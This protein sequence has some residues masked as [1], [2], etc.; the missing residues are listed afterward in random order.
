MKFKVASLFILLALLTFSFPLNNA[1]PTATASSPPA[2]P[3]LG[4]T[5]SFGL[6]ASTIT[7]TLST[8]DGDVGSGTGGQTA[9][10]T[11][12]PPG[13]NHKNNAA[14]TSAN[15]DL[16][17]AIANAR[18][19]TCDTTNA[20]AVTL[21]DS[22]PHGVH[23]IGGAATIP[24]T[25]TLNDNGGV[26]LFKISGAL[27]TAAASNV[28]LGIGVTS[29]KVFWLIDGATSIGAGSTFAGTVLT[30]A[31]V[32]VGAGSDINGRV[33]TTAAATISTSTITTAP[34]TIAPIMIS[35]I[36]LSETQISVTFSENLDALTVNAVDFTVT[37][38]I[39]TV[40]TAIVS[41]E[42]V[43]LNLPSSSLSPGDTPTVFLTGIV[44]DTAGNDS[45]LLQTVVASA[46]T[47]GAIFL[48]NAEPFGL[49]AYDIQNTNP[50]VVT[51]D[52]G[53]GLAGQSPAIGTYT[54]IHFN[55]PVYADANNDLITAI[56]DV[57]NRVCDFDYAGATVL[58]NT[59]PPGV[60]CIDGVANITGTLQLEG[61][62][63]YIFKIT[64]ALNSAVGTQVVLSAGAD[65]SQVFWAP[66]GATTLG[67]NSHLVGTILSNVAVT[68]GVG[69]S[70]DG[71]I[72]TTGTTT[73]S[74]SHITIP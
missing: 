48:G 27:A 67:T 49:L 58:I 50:T 46:F 63:V 42:V 25:I 32:T 68:A 39:A 21:T 34:D 37:T 1:I 15:A 28:E 12:V 10:V 9:P 3:P 18:A 54:N 7:N 70:I 2:S 22:Y 4:D 24:G 64:G 72:L 74:N 30:N 55:D 26:Y 47:T 43:I 61:T 38:P 40:N 5:A 14:Y 6:L 52:V 41:G 23:C 16:L 66:S 59:F 13:V 11:V 20:A 71:R 56:G 17:N 44:S 33:L 36:A 73:I 57:R 62:G 29:D 60:H 19:Q 53:S 31:A 65:S 8:V 45:V 35:A 51:G 69:S